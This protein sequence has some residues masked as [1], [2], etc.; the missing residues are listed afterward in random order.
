MFKLPFLKKKAL[1]KGKPPGIISPDGDLSGVRATIHETHYHSDILIDSLSHSL[2]EINLLDNQVNWY[3]IIHPG[4]EILE[5]LKARLDL[6]DLVLTDIMDQSLRPK[7]E[8]HES[9]I[10]VSLN[11]FRYNSVENTLDSVQNGILLGSNY[12]F[13]FQNADNTI[14]QDI[15]RRLKSKAGRIRKH[16]AD[17]LFFTLLDIIVDQHF[18]LLDSF[19]EKLSDMEEELLDSPESSILEEIY[20]LRKH[21]SILFRG[22]RPLRLIIKELMEEDNGLIR[23]STDR[24]LKSLY[25]D[26]YQ[27]IETIELFRETLSSNLEVYL[28]STNNKINETMKVLTSIATIFIPLTF[29]AGIYGMNFKY[30]PELAWDYAYFSVLGFMLLVAGSI[31][32]Y[33]KRK[34]WW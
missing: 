34:G 1:D 22:I 10:F 16:K 25:D 24:F 7:L 12:V 2:D 6:H 17:Y 29:I 3:H 21:L 13:S 8:V 18:V 26:I 14:F 19:S 4:G 32:Y 20:L 31:V 23:D 33:F 15:F 9:Y 5:K 30:M 11:H 27:L 28:S